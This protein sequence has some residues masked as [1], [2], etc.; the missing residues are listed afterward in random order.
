VVSEVS[1][2]KIPEAYLEQAWRT[3][4]DSIL[5]KAP[6]GLDLPFDNPRFEHLGHTA[7]SEVRPYGVFSYGSSQGHGRKTI[8]FY[9]SS[10]ESSGRPGTWYPFHGWNVGNRLNEKDPK[11][12]GWF[13]KP[14]TG[15]KEHGIDEPEWRNKVNAAFNENEHVG[16]R[17]GHA[18]LYDFYKWMNDP[19]NHSKEAQ[20][21]YD[22]AYKKW[23]I[24]YSPISEG[25][26]YGSTSAYDQKWEANQKLEDAGSMMMWPKVEE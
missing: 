16:D 10:G 24:F 7:D 17:V 20:E 12:H 22:H 23:G 5:L 21:G 13:V 19:A 1:S 4:K 9:R 8:P 14:G 15:L 3:L 6:H 2:F 18:R 25:S 26:E 11:Y